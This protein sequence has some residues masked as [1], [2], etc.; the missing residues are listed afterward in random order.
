MIFYCTDERQ[1][2]AGA[3]GGVF[4]DRAA[5]L[6]APVRFGRFDH[7][8]RHPVFHAAGRILA[9]DLQQN[10]RAFFRDDLAQRQQRCVAD[11]LEDV[12]VDAVVHG[13]F[14]PN[15]SMRSMTGAEA[16]RVGALAMSALAIGPFRWFCRPASSLN[17]SNTAN[18][19]GLI[20]SAN[21]TGV[22]V[23]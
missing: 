1:R 19:V 10:A 8:E 14:A 17:A 13:S 21:Q 5:R 12:V 23:S 20:C 9:L 18:V 3:S 16:R 4:D 6:E 2:H 15:T 7:R 11:A 22:V